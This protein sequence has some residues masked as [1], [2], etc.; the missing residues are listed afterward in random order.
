VE[1]AREGGIPRKA[2]LT[3]GDPLRP[4]GRLSIPT[5]RIRPDRTLGRI[6]ANRGTLLRLMRQEFGTLP[7]AVEE[8]VAA[9]EDASRLDDLLARI[10]TAA[11]IAEMGF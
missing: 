9:I 8:N 11:S 10:L 6:A 1:A 5:S 2:S 3:A 4:D 7:Q